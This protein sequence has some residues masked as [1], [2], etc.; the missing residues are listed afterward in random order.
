[1]LLTI[2]ILAVAAA[3]FICSGVAL[4]K[5]KSQTPAIAYAEKALK[6]V[7]IILAV[8]GVNRTGLG[9]YNY[10][11]QTNPMILQEMVEN[12]REAQT[13]DAGKEIKKYVA[14]NAALLEANAPIIGNVSGKKV[15]YLFSDYTCPYCMRVH[16]ELMR[17]ID[18]DP[19]VKL[20]L[21]N[22]SVHGVMSD[23]PAKAVIAAKIQDNAKA[24]KLDKL[25][26]SS[27]DWF[28]EARNGG[29]VEKKVSSAVMKLAKDAGLD[30][31]KLE[32]DMA[33]SR[34]VAQE[35]F[36]VRELTNRFQIS[37]TPYLII[38]NQ[39]FPGAIPY[40]QIKSA[41]NK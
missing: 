8:W 20:V 37:G 36:Q 13:R 2:I 18:E 29:D 23:I 19:E 40:E 21:K 17:V 12:M 33:E 14:N 38:N 16:G 11:A 24:A 35:L 27:T 31:K 1:M 41:L 22:F 30:I 6:F 5:A 9:T 10:L 34:E 26:T 32:K 7:A 15:I 4:A 25:L 39:S 28:S 3:L